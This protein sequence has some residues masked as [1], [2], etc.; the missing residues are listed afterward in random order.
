MPVQHV[1]ILDD[2]KEHVFKR[3]FTV[4]PLPSLVN[5]VAIISVAAVAFWPHSCANTV[6]AATGRQALG[7]SVM[8]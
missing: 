4:L 6:N 8:S 5:E 7:N 3:K 1:K 2:H